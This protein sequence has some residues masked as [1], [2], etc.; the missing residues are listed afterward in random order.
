MFQV[1]DLNISS[2]LTLL[3]VTTSVIALLCVVVA[4]VVQDLRLVKRVKSEQIESQ[5]SVL[6]S[7]IAYALAH[8]DVP[9]VSNLLENISTTHG[10]VAAAVFDRRDNLLAQH[11]ASAGQFAAPNNG[12]LFGSSSGTFERS[13]FWQNE[14]VGRLEA[15]VSYAD[16]QKRIAYML[17]YS[18]LAFLFAVAIALLVT[19]LVQRIV[20]VPLQN[21]AWLA[22]RVLQTGNY[23]LRARTQSSDELG[24]L[25]QAINEMLNQIEERDAMLEK[26]V[27]KRT[28]EL[29]RLA[30]EF[31]YRALHDSLTGL[32][33]RSLLNEEFQ[34]ASAHAN[35]ANRLFALLLLDLDNFKAINDS[36][37]HDTGDELLKCIATRLRGVLRGEDMICRLGGDEFVVLLEDVHTQQHLFTVAESL[38]EGLREPVEIGGHRLQVGGSIG[39]SIYPQHGANMD[40]LKHHADLAMYQ[41]KARGKQQLVIFEPSMAQVSRYEGIVQHDLQRGLQEGEMEL[42]FQPQVNLQNDTLLGSEALLRWRHPDLGLLLPKDFI[43]FAEDTGAVMEIDY[44]VLTRACEFCRQWQQEHSLHVPVAVNISATYFNSANLLMDIRSALASSGLSAE[45]LTLELSAA[46]LAPFTRGERTVRAIQA[47][48]VRVALGGFGLNPEALQCFGSVPLD[49]VKLDRKAFNRDG[50]ATGRLISGFQA[51]ALDMGVAVIVE[52]LE[53]S[54]QLASLRALGCLAGQGFVYAPPMP[55]EQFLHWVQAFVKE[56]PTPRAHPELVLG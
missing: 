25:A 53:S 52:G 32:P 39:A 41:A 4:F 16:V 46:S 40:Q 31:R 44:F 29:Q 13:I 30:D 54:E 15:A 14:E 36:Y 56:R 3:T 10:V 1:K 47:L 33:N 45:F 55:Q 8:N 9:A 2:K 42:Y 23:S 21:L 50:L 28:G 27:A 26:K 18:L 48:G 17:G 51:M 12:Q 37:G 24:Q 7:N 6:S 43:A 38:L 5:L 20:S 35:R 49:C 11:P 22:R 19:G 34:R